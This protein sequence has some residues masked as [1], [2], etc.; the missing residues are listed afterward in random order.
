MTRQMDTGSVFLGEQWDSEAKATPRLA[1]SIAE[2]SE[3]SRLSRSFIY[4]AMKTGELRSIK[5]RGR[6]LILHEDGKAW[7]QSFRLA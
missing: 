3:A 2:F 6:R 4:E 5:V 1:Y 7:L